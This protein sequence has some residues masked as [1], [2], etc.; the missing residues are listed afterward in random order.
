VSSCLGGS[1]S[2]VTRVTWLHPDGWIYIAA[3]R[4]AVGSSGAVVVA[5]SIPSEARAKRG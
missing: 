3:A 2:D 1:F 5:R 4:E